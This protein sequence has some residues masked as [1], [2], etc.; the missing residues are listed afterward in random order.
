[1]TSLYSK[2]PQNIPEGFTNPT[3]SF[4]KHVWLS[5]LGLLFFVIVYVV[6]IIWFG[7][8]AYYSFLDGDTFWHYVLAGGYAFLC[9][10]MIKSLFIFNKKEKNP[11]EKYVTQKEE[12]LLF[13][14]LHKLADEAG[15]PRP[16]K[17]FLSPRVNASVSYD[18]S[19]INL[20]IPSKKNLEIG[21]GLMNVLSLG[22]LKAVLAHEFGHFAQRS[23]LLG[24][25]VYVAQQI[26][27]QIINKRDIFDKFLAGISSIDIRISW[28]GWILS[29]LVWA[30]R[31]LIETCFSIV[32]IAQRALSREMEFQADLVAVS[33]TGSDALIHALSRLQAADEAYDQAIAAVDEK[34]N[35]GKAIY[36]LY[37]LQTNYIKKMSWVLNE[38]SYGKSPEVVTNSPG[39]NRVFGNRAYN[40]PKMWSTHPADKD[41]EANAK[42]TY[43][44]AEIDDRPA[45]DLLSDSR[46]Y[47]LEMTAKLIA[48]SG[49]K[50]EMITDEAS[51]EFQ[52][53]RFFDWTF[54]NP[55]YNSN[56]LNRFVTINFKNIEEMYSQDIKESN[57][58]SKFDLIYGKQLAEKL[59]TFKEINEEIAS[60]EAI[61]NEVI[62]IEKREIWHRGEK[63]K[64]KDVS[65]V[66]KKLEQEETAI[67]DDLKA[68]DTLCRSV[69]HKVALMHNDS[70]AQYLKSL[71][72]LVHY[73][74]HS[75][76]DIN[77]ASTKYNNVLSI[78]L[79]DGNVSSDELV[80][81]LDVG[82]DYFKSIR[83]AFQESKNIQLNK[84][85]LGNSDKDSYSDFFEEFKLE[86]PTKENINE[87]SKVIEGWAN[88]A[89]KGLNFLRNSSLEHLLDVEEYIRESFLNKT[90]ISR[91]FS[92]EIKTPESYKLLTPGTER[93]IQR[94]LK[95]WDRFMMGE[96]LFGATTK[97]AVSILLVGGALFLGSF[98]QSGN[99]TVYN[100]L[101]TDV[102]VDVVGVGKL[103]ILS[104]SNKSISIDYNTDYN[105]I[106]K[107]ST[108]EEIEN[109]RGTTGSPGQEF[110]Y[111]IASAGVFLEYTVYYGNSFGGVPN[112]RNIGAGKWL[113]SSAD[114]VL[115][116][117]PDRASEGSK[118]DVLVAYSDIAPYDM[119]S[120]VKDSIEMKNL[121]ET[122][123]R[124]DSSESDNILTW[125]NLLTY[126]D[127]PRV[128]LD[129]RISRTGNDMVSKRAKMDISTDEERDKICK[130]ISESFAQNSE[131][132]DLYYLNTRCLGDS[133]YQ[134]NTFV[135]GHE[136]W[137]KHPWLAYASAFIYARNEEWEKSLNAFNTAGTINGL[138]GTLAIHAEK[139]R[140]MAST[141]LIEK[142]LKFTS[143]DLD[144]Y[145]QIDN[146]LIG[147]VSGDL[148]YAHVLKTQG[149]LTE[150]YDFL[151]DY[152]AN[153]SYILRFLAVS[154]GVSEELKEKARDMKTEDGINDS[155]IWYSLAFDILENK[156]YSRYESDIET[157]GVTLKDLNDFIKA[158]TSDNYKTAESIIK[159]Q[160][161][162]FKGHMYAVGYIISGSKAPLKWR[163]LAKDLLLAHERPYLGD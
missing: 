151:K 116:T 129:Q 64:R 69:H 136:K 26:A 37:E 8:L 87:W 35:D 159:R 13:D 10:F 117:P 1:M 21:L 124:W 146:G 74:E 161:L 127:N 98:T 58:V 143:S 120:V 55:K 112:N 162:Y 59:E 110:I 153:T 106:T 125:I 156:N 33:L 31:S 139:V 149:K 81:I 20:I 99:L 103:K 70:L 42:K 32:T 41:R 27:V 34:L 92:T 7:R 68:H 128:V 97:F 122:H 36:N 38:P 49:A 54:L 23:M 113:S 86:S 5:I 163:N 80:N 134:D 94:K 61:F 2:G 148:G 133:E 50:T 150:S 45:E 9:L 47:E 71:S 75:I 158:V 52:N 145:L 56:F 76:A 147:K 19:I 11:L 138:K 157:M 102:V 154:E 51:L 121:I 28:I 140:R 53:T 48:T 4:K 17:V 160:Q 90:P 65:E 119:L 88:V 77:D 123:V 107:S 79:A 18:L 135:K 111:N 126:S 62:T 100:G 25:Y 73:S 96:G 131:D 15:A 83:S 130:Q 152:Q 78:S 67:I 109:F 82:R 101:G 104:N 118:K 137:H 89:L 132:A 3:S 63:I 12:P 114:Y 115:T 29:I 93:P 22:E 84:E 6:L 39:S 66:I 85:L 142:E 57:L 108:G 24:R 14:Y 46:K 72:A 155:T 95:F 40:P 60:L 43:I 44:S 105:I 91:H 141:E 16:H 30:V 144:Y